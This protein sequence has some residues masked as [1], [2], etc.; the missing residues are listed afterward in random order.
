[1]KKFGKRIL[2]VLAC[3]AVV[4]YFGL[5]AYL[6][7]SD[8]LTT[9]ACYTYQLEQTISV[10]GYVVRSEVVLTGQTSGLL[11]LS[12]TE[13]ERVSAGG[14]VAVVYADQASLD[15]Q[16]EIDTLETQIEQLQYAQ[17]SALS[18]EVSL[19]LDN[20][21]LSAMTSLRQ[22]LTADQLDEAEDY[23][24][25]LR[26]LILKRDYTYTNSDELDTQLQS[27]QSQLQTLKS[28]AASGTR[29]ITA[30]RSGIYSAVVDGY[31]SVLTPESLEDITPSE[32]L[33]VEAGPADSSGLGKLIAED[34]WYYAA[35][36]SES[37][38]A[39]LKEGQTLTLRFPK[40]ETQG[41]S[42]KIQ[43]ISKPESGRVAVVFSC[44][45]YVQDVTLL[46]QQS[47]EL[48]TESIT[49]LR[50]PKEAV[51]VD[52]EGKAGVYCIL[53]R[54]AQFKPVKVR[55]TGDEFVLVSSVSDTESARIR[56]GDEV[57][58]TANDLYNGK[59]VT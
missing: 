42:M 1:M 4:G 20:R 48:V 23:I 41:Y 12:R 40:G 59:I 24:A 28:Q 22:H 52:E 16:A 27:L 8:P 5:Q 29:T 6:Y 43:S 26:G 13:G 45:G 54:K 33:P 58:V 39:E 47:A 10:T 11:R 2:A 51:R 36:V 21:I 17:Q 46:R 25:T 49:G 37:D 53:G 55:Y 15:R 35:T 31:E 32:L 30:P 7:F 3:T 57:I 44:S 34:T 9:T 18:G 56:P 14:E 38:A 50:V 19:K